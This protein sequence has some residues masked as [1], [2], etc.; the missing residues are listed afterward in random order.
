MAATAKQDRPFEVV[1]WGATGFTGRL[2]AE[3]LARQYGSDL[4]WALAGRSRDRL[5]QVRSG[6]DGA[7]EDL[8][9]IVADSHDPASLQA[10]AAQTRV[11]LTTVGPYALYGN[12]LVAACVAE[13]TDYVD[14]AGEVQW[15]QRM[16]EKHQAEA[17]ETGARIVHC[18]GFDSIPSDMG[19]YFVQQQ[20]QAEFGEYCE[21]VGLRVKAA[22]GGASGGTIASMLNLVKEARS[23]KKVAKAVKNPYS[24]CPPDMQSG[25]RQAT[26]STPSFDKDVKAWLA[27]FVMAAIN[28]RVVHR[29]HA[30]LERVWGEDF[31]YDEAM[32]VGRG[33]SGR[34]KATVGSVG[35]GGF[36][37]A[38]AIGPTRTL[39]QKTFLPS[40]GEGPDRAE[41]EAG[42]FTMLLTGHTTSGGVIRAKVTGDRDPGYGSTSKMISEAAVCLASDVGDDVAGGFWT[43]STAM[44]G[45][46]LERLA[47]NAGL[48]FVR[49][50]D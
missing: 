10:M 31:R 23:D 20:A 45:A 5:E 17:V 44:N 50:D 9:V 49:L 16:I 41:R 11:V 28:T 38:A 27:P 14:L 42:F 26:H 29:S 22:K 6:L 19:V 46:L 21:R 47:A 35:L 36:L 32:M 15:V 13:G 2:V 40:P 39:M 3:Y 43:P 34:A 8:P 1:V 37:A 24:L 48:G 18:C 33:L 7:P 30:L 25:P 4:K 12:E